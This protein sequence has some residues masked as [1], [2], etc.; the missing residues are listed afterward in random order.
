MLFYTRDL[1]ITDFASVEG[2]GA[3]LLWTLRANNTEDLPHTPP[4]HSAKLVEG[5][6]SARLRTPL[7]PAASRPEPY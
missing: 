2:P 1:S 3:N 4:P 7:P 6:Q 5:H